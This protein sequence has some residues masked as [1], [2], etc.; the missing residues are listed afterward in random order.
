MRGGRIKMKEGM[1]AHR[2]LLVLFC[3][4]NEIQFLEM[5]NFE[6]YCQITNL[7]NTPLKIDFWY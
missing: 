2:C 3:S 5:V 4:D 7:D 1:I 6:P